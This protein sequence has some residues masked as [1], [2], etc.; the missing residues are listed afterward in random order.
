MTMLTIKYTSLLCIWTVAQSIYAASGES[1]DKRG[2]D[3]A[4]YEAPNWELTNVT[5]RKFYTQSPSPP[6]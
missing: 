6:P 4:L 2:N 5:R 1:H 3:K